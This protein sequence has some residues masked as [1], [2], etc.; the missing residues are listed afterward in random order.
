[1]DVKQPKGG[2]ACGPR[3]ASTVAVRAVG[4]H[5]EVGRVVPLIQAKSC[6]KLYYPRW[7]FGV[8]WHEIIPPTT[9]IQEGMGMKWSRDWIATSFH[10][11][12]DEPE[13]RQLSFRFTD[14]SL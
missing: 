6:E 1:M 10:P 11:G 14:L 3:R 2:G 5:E 7:N 8:R 4:Q 12:I 13:R 9:K